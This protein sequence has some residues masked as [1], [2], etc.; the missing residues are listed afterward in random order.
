MNFFSIFSKRVKPI[1]PKT[2]GGCMK[3][4]TGSHFC[5]PNDKEIS[6]ENIDEPHTH[7]EI[8]AGGEGYTGPYAPS[9][10]YG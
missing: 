7:I 6:Y 5:V 2:C 3:Q 1:A 10:D 9:G 4:F 8:R